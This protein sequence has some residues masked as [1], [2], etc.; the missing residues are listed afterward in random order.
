[1]QANPQDHKSFHFY[2]FLLNLE[3]V[4]SKGEITKI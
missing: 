2:F 1:M 4:E 3:I